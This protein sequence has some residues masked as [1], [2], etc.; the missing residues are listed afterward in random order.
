MPDGDRRNYRVSI[1][2]SEAERDGL[3][4]LSRA[5]DRSMSWLGRQAVLR[6]LDDF[7]RRGEREETPAA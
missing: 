3:E 4:Q 1:C 5:R 2:L 6:A 7:V